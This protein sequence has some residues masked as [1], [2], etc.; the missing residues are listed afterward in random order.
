VSA[1][2]GSV[3]VVRKDGVGLTRTGEEALLVDESGGSVHVVNRTAA[4]L[5][6]LCAGGPSVEGLVGSFAGSVELAP[7]TVR[8]D[9]AGMLRTFEQL[10]LVELTSAV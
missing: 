2:S 10:G 4:Q 3:R 7:E 9:V 5:W 8:D 1:L 6:E